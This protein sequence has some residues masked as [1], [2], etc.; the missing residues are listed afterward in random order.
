MID[1]HHPSKLL[2]LLDARTVPRRML[3]QRDAR[4]PGRL[5]RCVPAGL[6]ALLG[7]ARLP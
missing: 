2:T 1:V 3:L 7:H 5:V 4:W 6:E